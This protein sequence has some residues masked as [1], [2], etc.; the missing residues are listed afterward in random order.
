VSPRT[1]VTISTDAEQRFNA[2]FERHHADV[3]RY[4][5][6]RLD[7]SDAED[8]ASEVF[9]V[10]WR[11]LDQIPDTDMS[12]VWL[13]AVAY[14]IVGNQYRGR[15]RRGRLSA[16]L[17]GL[18]PELP[19]TAD[20]AIIRNEESEALRRA[21]QSL[22]ETDR[23]LLRLVSW[24][25]LSHREIGEVLGINEDTVSKRVSRAHS[26]LRTQFDRVYGPSSSTESKEASA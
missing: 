23:E 11:R 5:V 20:V 25:G 10:A 3:F 21:L 1:V 2:L 24:D 13:L 12:K 9:A 22:R 7:R 17:S 15:A 4:C 16:R 8:I 14:R 26:R 18:R 6:R 19:E